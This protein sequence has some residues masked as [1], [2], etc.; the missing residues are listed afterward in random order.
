MHRAKL[1]L[2]VASILGNL[3]GADPVARTR[4]A[5]ERPHRTASTFCGF[6]D[7]VVAIGGAVVNELERDRPADA[8]FRSCRRQKRGVIGNAK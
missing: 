3:S 4:V 7:S 5:P 1:P 6:G 2:A 8:M